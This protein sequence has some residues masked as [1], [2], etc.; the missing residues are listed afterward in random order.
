MVEA[1]EVAGVWRSMTC[2]VPSDLRSSVF[3]LVSRL[4]DIVERGG[5]YD[6]IESEVWPVVWLLGDVG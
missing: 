3:S 2:V 5:G 1:K 6:G 4:F